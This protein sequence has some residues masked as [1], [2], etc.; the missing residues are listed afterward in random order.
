MIILSTLKIKIKE[1]NIVNTNNNDTN[2]IILNYND[3]E[4]NSLDYNEALNVD[5]RT[6][7]IYYFSLIKTKH[8]I[9]FTFYTKNDYNSRVIKICLFLFF[10]S[11]YITVNA[12]FFNDST[13]HKI[14]IDQ[15]KYNLAYQIPQIIYSTII[16]S[17]INTIIKHLSLTETDIINMKKM[18]KSIEDTKKRFIIKFVLFFI[19]SF[20]FLILF[21]F[22][23]SCFC[24][25]YHNTQ[26]QLISDTLISFGLSLLYPFGIYLIPGLFRIPSLYIPNSQSLY[27]FSK[28]VQLI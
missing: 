11:L 13:M 1:Q 28:Y 8:L 9:L 16:T 5:K 27:K 7:L 2:K 24:A 4:I 14:Y 22:Y 15:G 12:L 3:Y 10:F 20:I 18:K 25:V 21:W 23:L 17:V 19:L 26:I 6:Y